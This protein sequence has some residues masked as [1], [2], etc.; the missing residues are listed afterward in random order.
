MWLTVI[1]NSTKR[2]ETIIFNVWRDFGRTGVMPLE[3]TKSK[4]VSHTFLPNPASRGMWWQWSV[5]NPWMY[6]QSKFCYCVTTK[7]LNIAIYTWVGRNYGQMDGQTTLQLLDALNRPFRLGGAKK[8]IKKS[9]GVCETLQ[10]APAATKLKKL[11]LASRSR[12]QGHLPWCR[13]KGHH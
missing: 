9:R 7:N 3:A 10:Y 12:S 6:L 4:S 1:S 2:P 11:F 13:L 8:S 5:S